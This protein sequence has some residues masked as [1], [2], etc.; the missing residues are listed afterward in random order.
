[1]L[2]L[3]RPLCPHNITTFL[4]VAHYSHRHTVTY[5]T[6]AHIPFLIILFQTVSG[7]SSLSVDRTGWKSFTF[8]V[9]N[10]NSSGSTQNISTHTHTHT[11]TEKLSVFV[12]QWK[13]FTTTA[14]G[15]LAALW[16]QTEFPS[17]SCVCVRARQKVFK[18]MGVCLTQ[19]VCVCV[20]E[21]LL[22]LLW[23]GKHRSILYLVLLCK[24][25]GARA[26][27]EEPLTM[28]EPGR[29]VWF[30]KTVWL[31]SIGSNAEVKGG[32][33]FGE[34]L[35]IRERKCFCRLRA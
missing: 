9:L 11:H 16:R 12:L 20:T 28:E 2:T 26:C 35:P 17:H 25:A 19:F 29:V 23:E 10:C 7:T 14:A 31:S 30:E 33:T 8:Y 13:I 21:C 32:F 1:M 24:L 22:D 15:C 18:F 3:T 6:L 34:T 5:V 4:L 27:F